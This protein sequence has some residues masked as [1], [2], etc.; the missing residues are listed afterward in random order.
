MSGRCFQIL[1]D[2]AQSGGTKDK[3]HFQNVRKRMK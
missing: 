1:K 3:V 2:V